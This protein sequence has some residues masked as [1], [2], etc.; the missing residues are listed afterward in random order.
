LY[1]KRQ[2]RKCSG[3]AALKLPEFIRVSEIVMTLL[4]GIAETLG[5]GQIAGDQ[6]AV[7]KLLL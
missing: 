5:W 7:T 3:R 6:S 1:E 4:Y 2:I